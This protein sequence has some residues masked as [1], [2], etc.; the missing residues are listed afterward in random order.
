MSVFLLAACFRA[1]TKVASKDFS[2]IA[3][4]K[5]KNVKVFVGASTDFQ[6]FFHVGVVEAVTDHDSVDNRAAHN[7]ENVRFRV[8]LDFVIVRVEQGVNLTVVLVEDL[9]SYSTYI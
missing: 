6:E 9:Q 4:T 7:E 3:T 8:E 5:S 1:K 2:I